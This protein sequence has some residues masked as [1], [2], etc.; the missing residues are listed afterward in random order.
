MG[1]ALPGKLPWKTSASFTLCR[2]IHSKI[3][4]HFEKQA[5]L[6]EVFNLVMGLVSEK[7]PLFVIRSSLLT[8]ALDSILMLKTHT[9]NIHTYRHRRPLSPLFPRTLSLSRRLSSFHS[10]TLR[11]PTSQNLFGGNIVAP[12]WLDG[13]TDINGKSF[14]GG[15]Y[16]PLFG[17]TDP[18]TPMG[19]GFLD[20]KCRDGR[21]LITVFSQKLS[22]N[23]GE[24]KLQFFW[25]SLLFP[26][27]CET[28]EFLCSNMTG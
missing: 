26:L 9:E 18:R 3:P 1:K 12:F 16:W 15:I 22:R 21:E 11:I 17:W 4:T 14:S 8:P 2:C 10:V 25:L 6:A 13:S 7:S 27:C 24:G 23:R 20:L 5:P 28:C 19:N